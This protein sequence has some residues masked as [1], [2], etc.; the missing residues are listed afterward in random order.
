MSPGG[1]DA[2]LDFARRLDA[3]GLEAVLAT[4]VHVR[5]S[6]YRRPGARMLILSDG[7]RIGSVSGGC[8]DGDVV[9]KAWWATEDDRPTVR[10][11][12][13]SSEDD[14]V[15]EFGLGCNGAVHVLLER[16]AT[17]ATRAALQFLRDCRTARRAGVMATV[18]RATESSAA[19]IGQR[20]FWT[21]AGV[22]GGDLAGSPFAPLVRPHAERALADQASRLLHL[23]ELDVALE[24]IAPRIQLVIFGAGHDAIPLVELAKRLGWTVTVADARTEY[25]RTDRFP[26]ADRVVL[27]GRERPLAGLDVGPES[28]VVVMTHHFPQDVDLLRALLPV[29]PRYLGLLGSAERAARVLAEIGQ[30][31][32]TAEVHAPIGLDLGGD[33]PEAIALAIMAEIQ[34]TLAGRSAVKLKLCSGAIHAPVEEIGAPGDAT[35]PRAQAAVCD[36]ASHA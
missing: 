9:R 35:W 31:A 3:Y 2:V 13:T 5:G 33:G 32:A 30:D 4:V 15:F 10:V 29:R 8:L 6:A 22:C 11:Y 24:W 28:V 7:T 19:A 1:I 16:S 21:A 36:L 18:V 26:D 12:D 17:P 23:G 34:A 27:L 25:A 14:A 20:L